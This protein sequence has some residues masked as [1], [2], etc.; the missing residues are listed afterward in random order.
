[1]EKMNGESYNS[2]NFHSGGVHNN[3][4][5]KNITKG[6]NRD[7]L[8][9]HFRYWWLKFQ[10]F[11]VYKLSITCDWFSR[12]FEATTKECWIAAADGNERIWN[13]T[14][15]ETGCSCNMFS[16]VLVVVNELPLPTTTGSE[17]WWLTDMRKTVVIF[18]KQQV[19]NIVTTG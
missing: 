16:H 4:G 5:P 2:S 15:I 6:H 19:R 14:Q 18:N 3:S 10:L 9:Q 1:M 11:K 17:E 12:T 13:K 7:N 8:F